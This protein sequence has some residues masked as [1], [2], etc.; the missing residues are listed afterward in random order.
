ML[1]HAPTLTALITV[2]HGQ[3]SSKNGRKYHKDSSYATLLR[4]NECG[5]SV[6]EGND[7]HEKI[8]SKIFNFVL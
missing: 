1:P 4:L 7:V 8:C 5:G 2:L 3:A 6:E